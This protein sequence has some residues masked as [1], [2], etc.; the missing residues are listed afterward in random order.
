M[1]QLHAICGLPRSGSTLLVNVLNQNPA[2]YASSTSALG[3][4]VGRTLQFWSNAVELKNDLIH[5][6]EGAENRMSRTVRGMANAWYED[7]EEPFV[8]DKGRGWL[9]IADQCSFL[10]PQM[11]LI[12]CVRDSREIFASILRQHL[13]YPLLQEAADGETIY[14]RA[15][16]LFD[17]KGM[18]G[19]PITYVEDVMAK[20][21]KNVIPL[22]YET[23]V[24][25]P[26]SELQKLYAE[27][28]LDWWDGHDFEDVQ[29]TATDVD[30]LYHDKYPHHDSTGRIE[31]RPAT[32]PEVVPGEIANL[33]ANRYPT[34]MRL[35][36]YA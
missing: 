9:V 18:V 32:W 1:K 27:L 14:A 13:R 3:P 21:M 7:R 26:K 16:R 10:W 11:R 33:I 2:F 8:F 5:D 35:F 6:K 24:E 28:G 31:K 29:D 34:F 25:N 17:P 12:C 4:T 22:I 36:G 20:K 19:G 15:E 23:F 30:G